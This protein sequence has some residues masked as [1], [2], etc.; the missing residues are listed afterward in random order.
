MNFKNRMKKASPNSVFKMDGYFVWCA[1]MTKGDDG[2]YYL[3]F[4]FW[5]KSDGFSAWVT[6]SKIGYAVSDNPYGGFKYR[7]ICLQGACGWDEACVH[8]PAVIEH[9]GKYYM[10][11]MGNHG[12]GEYWCHRNNQRIGVAVAD[13]PEGPWEHSKKPIID[14]S[15]D[16]FDSLMTS[17]PSVTA[18]NDG[19]FYMIYKGVTNNGNLP[20]GGAVVCGIA[21]ADN[22]CGP[23][24]KYGKPIMTNPNADKSVEDAFVWYENY[25]FY[26]LAKDF[27]GY[28]TKSG[29]NHI[30]IF[31]S[32]DCYNWNPCENPLAFKREI[33]WEDGTIQV[34][35][36]MERP[37]IYIED[38]KPTAL[39][40]A[41][42]PDGSEQITDSFNI[43]IPLCD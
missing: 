20:R 7:G 33:I 14:I 34:L 30:A 4:S 17:N 22:P 26:A 8:N 21:V 32:K 35:K 29:E 19:K 16:S 25:K 11:Y 40:C 15:P 3:Y 13:K 24:R 27:Q 31:E 28:Y 9:Q 12:N 41:C 36:R 42:A 43:I 6:K 1:T 38:G 39:M 5:P 2:L 23:F 10:Y 37:Q 18:G